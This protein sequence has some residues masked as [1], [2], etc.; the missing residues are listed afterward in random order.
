MQ[1]QIEFITRLSENPYYPV[2]VDNYPRLFDFEITS[3]GIIYFERLK[4]EWSSED[5]ISEKQCMYL[6]ML[7]LAYAVSKKDV[8]ECH[9]WQAFMFLIEKRIDLEDCNIKETLKQMGCIRDNPNYNPKLYKSHIIWKNK[10]LSV[11]DKS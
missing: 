4:K 10:I 11:I 9:N 8:K 2:S 7:H 1:E 6:S 3:N 5:E